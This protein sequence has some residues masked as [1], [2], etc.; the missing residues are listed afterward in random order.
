MRDRERNSLRDRRVL[1]QDLIHFSRRNFLP[2]AVDDLLE[3]AG[4]EKVAVRIQMAPIP[5]AEPPPDKGAAIGFGVVLISQHHIRAANHDFAVFSGGIRLPASSMIA[6]S[7]PAASPTEPGFRLPRREPVARN[8]WSSLGHPVGLDER[9]MKHAFH[10]RHELPRHRRGG[11]ADESQRRARH[12]ARMVHSVLQDLLVNRGCRRIPRGVKRLHPFKEL[13][14]GKAPRA[15]DARTRRERS[16]DRAQTMNVKERHHIQTTIALNQLEC[17]ANIM[18]GGTDVP[19]CQGHQ[20]RSC[21][22]SGSVKH[23]CDI[24]RLRES[25]LQI[26]RPWVIREFGPGH[27]NTV[28]ER[29]ETR[30]FFCPVSVQGSG[31]HELGQQR[32]PADILPAGTSSARQCKSA[33][34]KSNSWQR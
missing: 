19:V 33:R 27:L 24:I 22:C 21:S 30:L 15:N 11:G 32:L 23:Q 10:L 9:D 29:E 18:C 14:S 8:L 6:T 13:R 5:R 31:C 26:F 20:F 34:W 12:D 16:K 17:S 4:D 25:S 3:T 1:Q 2:S 28:L 7:G